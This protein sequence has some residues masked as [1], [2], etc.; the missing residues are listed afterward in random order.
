MPSG[1]TTPRVCDRPGC[2]RPAAARLVIDVRNCVVTVDDRI[3]EVGGAA[4]LCDV[5]AERIVPP[6][7]WVLDDR[8]N[9]R[10]RL[11]NVERAAERAAEPS[12][13]AGRLR[14]VRRR[15]SGEEQLHLEPGA[16]YA[17]PDAYRGVP[18]GEVPDADDPSPETL[19][20][21]DPIDAAGAVDV[22]GDDVVSERTLAPDEVRS[23][24]LARAFEA[25][26]SRTRPLGMLIPLQA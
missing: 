3:H 16:S 7:G 24:L 10:P 14:R 1:A 20:A 9:T 2:A 12:P 18:D 5:H 8:H 15:L 23:P 21:A 17:L 13:A 4:V 6:R 19:G 25:A 22:A 26:R 11:F